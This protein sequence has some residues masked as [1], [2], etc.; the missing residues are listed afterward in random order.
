MKP[1][2][3]IIATWR[4]AYEGIELAAEL[5]A[6]KGL[7]SDGV[8]KAIQY[9]EDFPYYKSVGFGGLPNEHGE[10]ELDAAYMDG[11][12]LAVG[13]IGGLMDYRNPVSIA[14]KLSDERYNNFLVGP[15]AEHY[16]HRH[17]F[18]R[19]NMLTDRAKQQWKKRVKQVQE[20]GLSP[21]DG[22]DTV[23][24][25][26]LDQQGRMISAT[27]TSGLFMKKKGRVGDSPLCGSGFYVDSDIGGA[28]A[29]GLGEDLMKGCL[30]YEI[31]RLMDSG[32]SPQKAADQALFGFSDKL[33][34]KYGKVGAMSV[35]CMNSQ[36]EWGVATNVEFSFVVATSDL[37]PTIFIANP[38]G[39]ETSYEPATQKWLDAYQTRIHAPI[40]EEE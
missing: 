26:S 31:V 21:Y 28:T 19:K 5:L 27:S 1:N 35:V 16:A 29:T 12:T 23:G 36:G 9:V 6:N 11:N 24:M 25:I 15:G 13:A 38:N 39:N 7:A 2:W 18:T 20:Q 34:R 14:K 32:M 40:N 4:M 33:A 3:G 8:E 10:V 30:S 37:V 22:H 17:G